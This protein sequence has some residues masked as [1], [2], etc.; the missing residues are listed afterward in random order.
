MKRYEEALAQL[1]ELE[2]NATSRKENA[3]ATLEEAFKLFQENSNQTASAAIAKAGNAADVLSQLDVSSVPP[4]MTLPPGI[5]PPGVESS[6]SSSSSNS[7]PQPLFAKLV[8]PPLGN[9]AM[10]SSST[11]NS[12]KGGISNPGAA[13]KSAMESAGFP[14]LASDDEAVAEEEDQGE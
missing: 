12:Q 1:K 7:S 2:V 5:S 11:D 6:S 13:V 4:M 14:M 8:P 9:V 3:S 10:G